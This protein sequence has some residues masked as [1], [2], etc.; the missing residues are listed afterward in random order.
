[1][2]LI[3][4]CAGEDCG[5]EYNA[6]TEEEEW[7]CPYCKRNKINEYYP[8]LTAKLMQAE[9]DKDANEWKKVT[10]EIIKKARKIITE[11]NKRITELEEEIKNMQKMVG[12]PPSQN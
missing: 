5:R 4:V 6:D 11:K 3:I 7:V 1:M 9:I 8:F 12:K 2:R 10:K